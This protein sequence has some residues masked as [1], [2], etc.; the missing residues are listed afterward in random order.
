MIYMRIRSYL[1]GT[2]FVENNASTDSNASNAK[3]I[4]S[5]CGAAIGV[6]TFIPFLASDNRW[7]F[8]TS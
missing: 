1:G 8:R 3:R 7:R 6:M 2:K 4:T 5:Y